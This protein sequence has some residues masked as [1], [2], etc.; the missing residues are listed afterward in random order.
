L[1]VRELTRLRFATASR[2]FDT[3]DMTMISAIYTEALL[4]YPEDIV[5]RVCRDWPKQAKFWPA[6][7]ELVE[8]AERMMVERRNLAEALARGPR[9]PPEPDP[10]ED[11]RR[12]AIAAQERRYAEA[13]AF[14]AAH[15]ELMSGSDYGK[16][17]PVAPLFYETEP[18]RG[19]EAPP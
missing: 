13:A 2:E 4:E 16:P 7:A 17:A 9:R 15:P 11:E 10:E 5:V 12:A 3:A 14:R 1:V 19:W 8:P 18:P 6:L